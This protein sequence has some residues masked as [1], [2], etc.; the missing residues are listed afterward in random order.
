MEPVC[1]DII[2]KWRGDEETG[3]DQLDE[4]LREVVVI[5]DS[6]EE[7][8]ESE[9]D[10]SPEPM[11]ISHSN[12]PAQVSSTR[13]QRRTPGSKSIPM[14]ASSGQ[15]ADPRLALRTP[16]QA[17]A[18]VEAQHDRRMP[19]GLQRYEAAWQ[20]ALRRRQDSLHIDSDY[21]ERLVE[22]PATNLSRTS[23]AVHGYGIT[24]S[25]TSQHQWPRPID[26]DRSSL[27]REFRSDDA[28]YV[29]RPVSSTPPREVVHLGPSI[30]AQR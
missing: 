28:Y 9:E 19:R 24:Q 20:A 4:I 11:E 26:P 15:L 25:S 22:A 7:D 14:Q 12:S 21:R 5:T 18:V 2:A 3:R 27:K 10:D 29:P 8:D 30:F 16:S 1:L 23:M 13:P 17:P 6:E